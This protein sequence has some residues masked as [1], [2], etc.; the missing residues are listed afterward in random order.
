MKDGQLDGHICLGT[1]QI[2]A[3]LGFDLFHMHDYCLAVT[4]LMQPQMER[5]DHREVVSMGQLRG[6]QFRIRLL[7]LICNQQMTYPDAFL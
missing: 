7:R 6:F 1:G 2:E 3:R 5:L 4:C